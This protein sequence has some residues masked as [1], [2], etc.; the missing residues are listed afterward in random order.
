MVRLTRKK[1]VTN[2]SSNVK[3]NGI[4]RLLRAPVRY[5]KCKIESAY[6][7]LVKKGPRKTAKVV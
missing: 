2:T 4:L 3:K 1:K 7:R 6:K 5:V